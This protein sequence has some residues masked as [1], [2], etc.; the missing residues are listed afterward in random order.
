M[1]FIIRHRF[2]HSIKNQTGNDFNKGGFKS[3]GLKYCK[4]SGL[5]K[6]CLT[7]EAQK[8]AIRVYLFKNLEKIR[9]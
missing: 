8:A 6:R 2:V 4:I 3:K 9:V 5:K 7:D 1:F